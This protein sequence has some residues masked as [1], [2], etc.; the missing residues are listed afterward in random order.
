MPLILKTERLYL[1]NL[2]PADAQTMFAYRN[3]PR[4]YK[5]QRWK[6]TSMEAIRAFIADFQED[7]FLSRKPEQHYAICTHD[8]QIVGD[9]AYF[10]TEKDN[11]ITLGITVSPHEIRHGYATA[12]Y[13]AGVDFKLAQKFL[14]HAQ[15]STT[16][17]IY[18][19]ILDT[20]IDKVAAQMD[21]AF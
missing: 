17:D 7:T 18:T 11:C 14:G 12:L 15:L 3:D 20:R 21:A 10:Y 4:C 5:F 8:D 1:R 19:D 13:E 6:D 9:M 16:M 2:C